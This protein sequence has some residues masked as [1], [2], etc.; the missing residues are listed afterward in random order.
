LNYQ[1]LKFGYV[2]IDVWVSELQP[3]KLVSSS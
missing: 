3:L 1:V 2:A